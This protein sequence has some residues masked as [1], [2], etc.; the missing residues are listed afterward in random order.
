MVKISV[1][2]PCYNLGEYILPCLES[3]GKQKIGD[4][5]YIFV[6]DGSTDDTLKHIQEFCKEKSYCKII[7]KT[8]SGVSEARNEAL[9]IASGEYLYLLDGDDILTDNAVEQM[10]TTVE[11]L[12]CDAVLSDV[13]V[14]T[15]GKEKLLPLSLQDGIYT[16]TEVY[17]KVKVFPTIPQILYKREI[18]ENQSLK[19]DSNLRFG[20]V[21]D[22]TI[23]FLCFSKRIKIVSECYFKY[24]MRKESASHIPNYQKDLS[25]ISTLKKYNRVG[26]QFSSLPSFNTTSFK[27]VMAFTYNKYAKLRLLDDGALENIRQLLYNP[28]VKTLMKEVASTSSSVKDRVLATYI[29]MTGL[30][31]YKFLTHLI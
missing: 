20:E 23:R 3:I 27:M 7:D 11:N 6:N 10:I 13:I 31:G 28:E 24:V 26:V 25:I 8:N 2:I 16:P 18:I 5:E 19:F 4:T 12:D 29:L 14:L 30:K 22:F 17:R 21:Y 15:D 9:K 1:I